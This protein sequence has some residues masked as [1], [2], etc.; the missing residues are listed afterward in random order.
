MNGIIILIV[1]FF[2][3][4]YYAYYKIIND[5]SLLMICFN[6]LPIYPLD[7]YRIIKII[8]EMYFDNEYTTE[9]CYYLSML[10]IVI[11]GI[12]F[13]IFSKWLYLIIVFS[14]FIM[15]LKNKKTLI[16]KISYISYFFKEI[17]Y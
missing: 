6:L 16:N 4:N 14:L 3:E 2:K 11:L 13:I 5:Y 8:L 12:A 9:V 17:T 7:G 1:S 10:L 15:N